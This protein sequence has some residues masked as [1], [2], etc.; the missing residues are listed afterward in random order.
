MGTVPQSALGYII[1]SIL[2]YTCSCYMAMPIGIVGQAFSDVWTDRDRL[3]L[4]SRTRERLKENGY[5]ATEIPQ[6]FFLFDM[7]RDGQLSLDEFQQMMTEMKVGLG[8]DRLV[9]LFKTFD[10]DES[11][12]IDDQEFVK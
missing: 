3:I 5:T 1:V 9:K 8:A 2:I 10:T 7:D 12:G 4:M 6:L 11:G